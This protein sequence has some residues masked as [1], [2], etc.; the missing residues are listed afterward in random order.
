MLT[1]ILRRGGLGFLPYDIPEA[2][3]LLGSVIDK[4]EGENEKKR[5]RRRER[6]AATDHIYRSLSRWYYSEAGME[7]YFCS[8]FITLLIDLGSLLSADRTPILQYLR[9]YCWDH[10]L[11]D[12][13]SW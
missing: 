3:D 10:L 1:R 2:Q 13:T 8:V 5:T 4:R 9:T 11:Q 6:E 7:M 12:A